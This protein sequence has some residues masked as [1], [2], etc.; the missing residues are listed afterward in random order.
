MAQQKVNGETVNRPMME[1]AFQPKFIIEQAMASCK[2]ENTE[3]HFT[4]KN[5]ED[6]LLN[7]F[8]KAPESKMFG[9]A[10]I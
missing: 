6:A 1:E 3:P 2:F 10:R 4:A 9:V 7:L 5:V 8:V